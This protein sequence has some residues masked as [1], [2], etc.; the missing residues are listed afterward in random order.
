MSALHA[1]HLHTWPHAASNKVRPALIWCP[2]QRLHP[3]SRQY[4]NSL[5]DL[6]LQ[7]WATL[8]W[9]TLNLGPRQAPLNTH[10]P[11]GQWGGGWMSPCKSR[12]PAHISTSAPQH[13]HTYP[14]PGERW[15]IEHWYFCI[16][17]VQL[18][19]RPLSV[20]KR[21][22]DFLRIPVRLSRLSEFYISGRW[23]CQI[24]I[25]PHFDVKPQYLKRKKLL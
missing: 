1:V 2:T 5:L 13:R 24:Q 9:E 17:L 3:P 19:T 7:S 23:L 25:E 14:P 16:F 20:G 8:R 12:W 18:Q 6:P 22:Q 4:S 10:S 15:I 21:H 11:P